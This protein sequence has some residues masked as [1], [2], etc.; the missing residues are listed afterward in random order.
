MIPGLGRSP[1]EGK[2]YP[3]QYSG[4]GNS[5]DCI[6]CGVAKSRTSLNK[7]HFQVITCK[8]PRRG[9]DGG[10]DRN[11]CCCSVTVTG[12]ITQSLDMPAARSGDQIAFLHPVSPR[13]PTRSASPVSML[14]E[15]DF[16]LQ[17]TLPTL[18][19]KVLLCFAL[20]LLLAN[21]PS[22]ALGLTNYY[23]SQSSL[24]EV[25]ESSCLKE[26]LLMKPWDE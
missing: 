4:L 13:P 24:D 8:L 11:S 1:G 21:T 2:G 18:P 9:E 3:L 20:R 23:T 26:E 5:M 7:F 12:V 16:S 22:R 14:P 17:K 19:L 10:D 15:S 25:L 6:V